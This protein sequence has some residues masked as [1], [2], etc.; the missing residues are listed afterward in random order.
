MYIGTGDFN[1]VIAKL[2]KNNAI[3]AGYKDIYNKLRLLKHGY[4]FKKHVMDQI[5][6]GGTL[7]DEDLIAD[8]D[9]LKVF[10]DKNRSYKLK[11]GTL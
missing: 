5:T 8:S 6:E 10:Q 2:A 7:V 11:D 9:K 4:L 1:S 3:Q